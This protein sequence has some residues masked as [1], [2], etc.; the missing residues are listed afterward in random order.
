GEFLLGEPRAE[1]YMRPF[2]GSEEFING[3]ERWIL[4]LED[5]PPGELRSMPKVMERIAAVKQYRKKS[6]SASTRSLGDSPTR[7]HVT[8]VPNR[9]FLVI[10]ETSSER[11]EYVPIGWLQ[12]PVVPSNLVRV[13]LDA[14]LWHFGIL[15][16]RMH[17]AWLRYIGGRLESRYRYSIGIVYNPF[18]W[19]EADDR[20]RARICDLAQKVIDVR[21]KLPEASMADLYDS[22]VM[23]PELRQA[24]RALDAAVDKLYRS[25]AFPGD[26]QR[27]EHLFMLYEKLVS[28]LTA[29][30]KKRRGRLG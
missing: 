1:K 25:E 3:G 23:K 11:R 30:P 19:P 18:P 16:S 22:D 20:Q 5:A 2:V 4:Y 28:P 7:F 24:H 17:M 12:P 8:V 29:V 6:T 10:P 13:L 14:D 15:T 27:V 21:A 9:S 26:R